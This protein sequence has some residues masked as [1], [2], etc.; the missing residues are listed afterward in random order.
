MQK[1]VGSNPITRSSA[2]VGF[3]IGPE[4]CS[5]PPCVHEAGFLF[6]VYASRIACPVC[7]AFVKGLSES[8]A[9][10]TA[11]IGRRLPPPPV[12]SPL[13]PRDTA[14]IISP[15]P[16]PRGRPGSFPR[17]C[18]TAS[19]VESLVQQRA[20]VAHPVCRWNRLWPWARS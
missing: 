8:S 9:P 1:V 7:G 20:A 17:R 4:D 5:G 12:P 19:V 2:E 15:L 11:P 3:E 18:S 14:R 13:A 6:W 16:V 10:R